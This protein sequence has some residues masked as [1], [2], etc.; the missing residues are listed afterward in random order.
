MEGGISTRHLKSNPLAAIYKLEIGLSAALYEL[1][2]SY[3]NPKT[4]EEVADEA[5]NNILKLM[6]DLQ[7]PSIERAKYSSLAPLRRRSP[8]V[9]NDDSIIIDPR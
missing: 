8:I 3:G 4:L 6:R 9:R 2:S 7:T 1:N 5:R